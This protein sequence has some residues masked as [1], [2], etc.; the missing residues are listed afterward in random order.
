MDHKRR[1]TCRLPVV[2]TYCV[3]CGTYN[4]IVIP[5]IKAL[6]SSLKRAG[7]INCTF[8]F[9]EQCSPD[10]SGPPDLGCCRNHVN[11][12]GRY[13]GGHHPPPPPPRLLIGL[14][15]SSSYWCPE[16]AL[17]FLVLRR[18]QSRTGEVRL[19][20]HS[21]YGNLPAVRLTML[22]TGHNARGRPKACCCML[23]PRDKCPSLAR[24]QTHAVYIP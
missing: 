9:R 7:L 6:A 16:A 13:L 12:V 14:R 10:C 23:P 11:R 24:G 2:A 4:T 3:T 5:L 8:L 19:L 1:H 18:P 17:R 22:P 15:C 21:T 20:L